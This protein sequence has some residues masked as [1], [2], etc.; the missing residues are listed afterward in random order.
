MFLTLNSEIGKKNY[1]T[2]SFIVTV[3]HFLNI[4]NFPLNNGF[5][6]KQRGVGFVHCL[7]NKKL[8][9]NFFQLFFQYIILF[10]CEKPIQ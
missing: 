5:P 7:Q 1:R 8:F 4:D 2:R 9:E 10:Q 3:Q 6:D